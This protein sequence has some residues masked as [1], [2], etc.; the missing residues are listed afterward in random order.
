MT[1][2]KY[3]DGYVLA[4]P[5]GRVADY[6][7]MAKEG[8]EMWKKFGALDYKECMANDIKPKP[9]MSKL[10]FSTMVK[11]KKGET[12][13]FSYVTYKSKAHRDMVNK[14]VM[15]HFAKKYTDKNM[16]EWMM[17]MRMAFGGFTVEVSG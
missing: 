13:W 6:R 8:A 7:K 14:K 11:A 5:K 17:K 1:K 3:V 16:P 2:A 10:N 4:V 15:A 9:G 12:V